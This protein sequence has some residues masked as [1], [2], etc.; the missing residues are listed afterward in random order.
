[1][2]IPPKFKVP[3]EYPTPHFQYDFRPDGNHVLQQQ[4]RLEDG[5]KEWRD[6]PVV[7][8]SRSGVSFG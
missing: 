6:I 2:E 3:M 4:W 7:M 1:M 8:T 5:T